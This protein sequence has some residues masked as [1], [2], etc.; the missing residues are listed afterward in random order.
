M[1]SPPYQ[2][3]TEVPCISHVGYP[4][5]NRYLFLDSVDLYKKYP[6]EQYDRLLRNIYS[7]LS[8]KPV[9]DPALSPFNQDVWITEGDS[10][11]FWFLMHPLEPL[12]N[13][14]PNSI[15]TITPDPN[16]FYCINQ[17]SPKG[18]MTKGFSLIR[19]EDSL[20][21]F[22]TPVDIKEYYTITSDVN[23]TM[24]FDGQVLILSAVRYDSRGLD[25][26]VCFR[27]ANT[28]GVLPSI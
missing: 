3:G 21:T 6:P 4:E 15:V 1:K 19:R 25:L 20:W 9:K 12:N 28:N 27:K 16:A 18:D 7:D 8:G 26:Y 14:L 10:A 2:A 13:A 23:L 24:S 11:D 5:F 17:F 22:P